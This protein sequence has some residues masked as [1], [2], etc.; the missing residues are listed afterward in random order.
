MSLL[1]MTAGWV[2]RISPPIDGS[3]A[4]HQTSPRCGGL[5]GLIGDIPGQAFDPLRGIALALARSAGLDLPLA[6]ATKQQFDVMVAHGLG[7]LDK[8]GV[9]ELTFKSRHAPTLAR[10]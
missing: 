3:N 8:S 9:A 4:T 1:T 6:A 7:E 10:A 2:L 5:S